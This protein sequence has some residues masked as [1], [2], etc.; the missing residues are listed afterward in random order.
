MRRRARSRRRP[1]ERQ[2][3]SPRAATALRVHVAPV[4]DLSVE[5]LGVS[6]VDPHVLEQALQR[7]G[8]QFS[9]VERVVDGRLG[10]YL[11]QAA[12]PGGRP[13]VCLHG[14]SKAGKTRSLLHAIQVHLPDAIVVAPDR[15]RDTFRLCSTG[16]RSR[17]PPPQD[18]RSFYGSMTSRGSCDSEAREWTGAASATSNSDCQRLWS[19]NRGGTRTLTAS[20]EQKGQLQEPLR[21]ILAHA[22]S[23]ELRRPATPGER[24]AF[25][26][27]VGANPLRRCEAR[28]AQWPSG[29][30]LVRIL[31]SESHPHVDDG[32]PNH[33]G[34]A[35]TWAAVTAYRLGMT[36]PIPQDLLRRLFA[37]YASSEDGSTPRSNGR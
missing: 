33:R 14:P 24:Q 13:L 11:S 1:R 27:A 18:C 29:I 26:A 37:C 25:Q 32:K 5:D 4:A 36:T 12:K 2:R 35:L 31:T 6:P 28:W 34:A 9:Y 23:E 30:R 16:V 3:L 22:V 21:D 10:E 7:Q 8:D 17:S 15:T 19:R 20:P